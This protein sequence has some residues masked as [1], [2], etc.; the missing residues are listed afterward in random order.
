ME[1]E[2]DS[3]EYVSDGEY[4][5]APGMSEVVV[6]ELVPIKQDLESKGILQEVQEACGRGLLD[7][8]VV[9]F[10]DE[11]TVAENVMPVW[12]QVECL[13]PEDHVMSSPCVCSSK[14]SHIASIPVNIYLNY[15]V[16]KG[17]EHKC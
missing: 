12:I 6:R 5:T 17:I 2:S 4:K 8:L 13:M 11:V 14:P 7:H 9:I 1:E 10:D 16:A 3:L 15:I